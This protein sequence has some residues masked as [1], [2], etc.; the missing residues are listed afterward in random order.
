MKTIGW[1]VGVTLAAAAAY[2]FVFELPKAQALQKERAAQI[3]VIMEERRLSALRAEAAREDARRR[4]LLAATPSQLNELAEQCAE[5]IRKEYVSSS[6]FRWDFTSINP[7]DFNNIKAM[8]LRNVP[9]TASGTEASPRQASAMTAARA[10]DLISHGIAPQ[11]FDFIVL[12]VDDTFSGLR[13]SLRL[14]RCSLRGMQIS[15][16]RS[17]DSLRLP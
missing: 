12:R 11:S 8:A 17:V 7:S 4:E 3:E 16:P 10:A 6:V 15:S 1:L 13:R 9:M 14:H 2:Y 5:L